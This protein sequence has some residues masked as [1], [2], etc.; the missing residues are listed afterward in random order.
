MK[1][2]NFGLRMKQTSENTEKFHLRMLIVILIRSWQTFIGHNLITL[3][4]T[5]TCNGSFF[6]YSCRVSVAESVLLSGEMLKLTIFLDKETYK[7]DYKL[8][9][10]KSCHKLLPTYFAVLTFE[11][12]LTD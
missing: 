7:Q 6:F 11:Q 10:L 8:K 12:C 5:V 9:F 4:P 2:L 3:Q 1:I